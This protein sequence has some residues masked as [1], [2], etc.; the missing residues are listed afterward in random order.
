[1]LRYSLDNRKTTFAVEQT[2][3][4]A[5]HEFIIYMNE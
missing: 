4:F 3:L 5:L 2:V 1:M